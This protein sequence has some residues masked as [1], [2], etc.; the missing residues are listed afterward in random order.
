ME[1]EVVLRKSQLTDEDVERLVADLSGRRR[2]CKVLDLSYNAKV[3]DLGAWHVG[4]LLVKDRSI[5]TVLLDGT[6]LTDKGLVVLSRALSENRSVRSLSVQGTGIT[7]DGVE[8]FALVIKL[9]NTTLRVFRGP[10]HLPAVPGLS[11]TLPDKAALGP[12][13]VKKKL[14]HK[15]SPYG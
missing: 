1:G 8:T 5:E 2:G 10:P 7:A 11:N 4:R 3:T 14:P 13:S 6:T 9:H 12:A 15:L